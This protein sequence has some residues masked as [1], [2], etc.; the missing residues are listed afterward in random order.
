MSKILTW[1]VVHTN[2]ID[3]FIQG[4]YSEVLRKYTSTRVVKFFSIEDRIF[5]DFWGFMQ[6][7]NSAIVAQK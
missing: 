6:L 1:H 5:S 4:S 2:K 3:L 7:L